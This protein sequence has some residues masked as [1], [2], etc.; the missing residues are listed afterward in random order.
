MTWPG[1]RGARGV[2]FPRRTTCQV[3]ELTAI[4]E[5]FDRQELDN[6]VDVSSFGELGRVR[7]RREWNGMGT[8][9]KRRAYGGM[10]RGSSSA[11]AGRGRV[12][13]G[14]EG[15]GIIVNNLQHDGKL[16]NEHG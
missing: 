4:P 2:R 13:A 16:G 15:E 1:T 10:G 12:L 6:E 8:P 5:P 7:A 11:S 14:T 3:A 9:Q